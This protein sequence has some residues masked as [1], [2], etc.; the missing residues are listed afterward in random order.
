MNDANVIK[1]LK[2]KKGKEFVRLIL[3]QTDIKIF[4]SSPACSRLISVL[5]SCIA[6][7]PKVRRALKQNNDIDDYDPIEHEGLNFVD[8]TGIHL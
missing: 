4:T 3:R 2:A 6:S 8:V 5:E 7:P 1:P